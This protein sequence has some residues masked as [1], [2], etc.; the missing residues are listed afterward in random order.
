MLSYLCEFGHVPPLSQELISLPI[1]VEPGPIEV[2]ARQRNHGHLIVEVLIDVRFRYVVHLPPLHLL[3]QVA[4]VLIDPDL[5]LNQLLR[6]LERDV[7]QLPHTQVLVLS[8]LLRNVLP[9]QELGLGVSALVDEFLLD[10]RLEFMG[11]R[12]ERE[13]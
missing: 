7:P 4:P 10:H 1:N 9:L 12:G 8:E 5:R 2:L 13:F 6:L 11:V 3:R